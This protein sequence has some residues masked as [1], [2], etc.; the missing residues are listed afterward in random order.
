M[1]LFSKKE[2]F[3]DF[4]LIVTIDDVEFN[5]P[6]EESIQKHYVNYLGGFLPKGGYKITSTIEEDGAFFQKWEYSWEDNSA[7]PGYGRDKKHTIEIYVFK[8]KT[9]E[10]V[11]SEFEAQ[12]KKWKIKSGV[13]YGNYSGYLIQKKGL[14]KSTPYWF[15]FVKDGKTVAVHD[16][17]EKLEHGEK[18]LFKDYF[19]INIEK[20]IK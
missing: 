20:I 4:N 8:D 12:E 10:H 17:G 6:D 3:S 16:N 11:A 19:K 13:S 18:P 15:L 9:I 1:G 7:R 2:K 5:I 14:V